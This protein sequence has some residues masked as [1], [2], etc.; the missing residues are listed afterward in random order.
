MFRSLWVAALFVGLAGCLNEEI[1]HSTYRGK[2][3]DVPNLPEAS[4]AA[5]LRVDQVGQKLIHHN[6]LLGIEPTFHTYGQ[7][8][9]EIFHPDL[10]GV[11]I[12]EGLVTKCQ[13]DDELA[14]EDDAAAEEQDG[15]AIISVPDSLPFSVRIR[16]SGEGP[17]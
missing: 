3:I 13:S 17:C 10:N 14:A 12:T 4:V 5:A 6:P 16:P 7:K 9:P 1:D 11:F 2:A 15:R 8:D